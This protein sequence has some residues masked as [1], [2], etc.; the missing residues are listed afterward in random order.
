M[1]EENRIKV[2]LRRILIL[3]KFLLSGVKLLFSKP[4]WKDKLIIN[5]TVSSLFV[6]LLLLIYLLYNKKEAGSP[7]ILHYN[8]IFG[9]DYRGDYEQIYLIV[10]IGLIVI[11]INSALGY[12]LYLREKLASY[13]LVFSALLVQVFLFVAGY[14]IVAIN[15]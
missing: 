4:Y 14:L 12:F 9:D 5:L 10:L 2:I 3:K 6:N 8:F 15:S 7:V 1:S 13:M 11:I